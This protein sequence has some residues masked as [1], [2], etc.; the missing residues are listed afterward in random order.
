MSFV[1]K[2]AYI[3]YALTLCLGPLL[4]VKKSLIFF[5]AVIIISFSADTK[6]IILIHVD[7]TSNTI[8]YSYPIWSYRFQLQG[9]SDPRKA[10]DELIKY[11]IIPHFQLWK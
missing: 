8:V 5:T 4:Q 1:Q 6:L 7:E 11:S 10:W 3:L 9:A 2:N